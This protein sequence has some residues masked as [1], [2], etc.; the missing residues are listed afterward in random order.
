ML[1]RRF[2]TEH[3][4]GAEYLLTDKGAGWGRPLRPGSNGAKSIRGETVDYP[5]S[6]R[7]SCT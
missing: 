4:P 7:R 1:E 6:D 5:A 3:P 2:Y